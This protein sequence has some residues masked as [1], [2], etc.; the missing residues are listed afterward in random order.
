MIPVLAPPAPQQSVNIYPYD[1]IYFL[2]T[3]HVN[4]FGLR[5]SYHQFLSKNFKHIHPYQ[6]VINNLLFSYFLLFSPIFF[7]FCI[8]R[9]WFQ[10]M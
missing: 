9:G 4:P 7:Y 5:I 6:Q 1:L 8:Y 3:P 10:G 2:N